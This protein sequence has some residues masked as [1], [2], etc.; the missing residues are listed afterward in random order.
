MRRRLCGVLYHGHRSGSRVP[1]GLAGRARP[2][3]RA[4]AYPVGAVCIVLVAAAALVALRARAAGGAAPR[5]RT[6]AR[7]RSCR[8]ARRTRVL[9][10]CPLPLVRNVDVR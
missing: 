9:L 10:S 4:A 5:R 3:V 7:R 8:T 2:L 6:T 1:D